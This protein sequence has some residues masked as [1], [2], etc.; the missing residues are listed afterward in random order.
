MDKLE[1]FYK[2]LLKQI[3]SLPDTVADPAVYILTGTIP[4]EGVIHSRAL[5]LFGSICRLSEDS[6]EKQIARRQLSV[7]G[8]KSNSWFIDIKNI[9]L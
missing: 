8:D 2:K 7:K 9:L 5:N 4:I 6:I 1:K 3:L